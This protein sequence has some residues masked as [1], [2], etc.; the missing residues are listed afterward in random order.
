MELLC[1]I[2]LFGCSRFYTGRCHVT[3]SFRIVDDDGDRKLRFDEFIKGL[4]NY[5]LIV[6]KEEAKQIFDAFDRDKSGTISF[7]EFLYS[8]RVGG[9]AV[10]LTEEEHCSDL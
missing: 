10:S 7:D 8:L 4:D 9:H 3:R 1:E 6:P 2:Q 5:G